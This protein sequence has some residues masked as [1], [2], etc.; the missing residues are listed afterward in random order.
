MFGSLSTK[1]C[2]TGKASVSKKGRARA[3]RQRSK[4]SIWNN[5]YRK[6]VCINALLQRGLLDDSPLITLT[7]A[8]M[9]P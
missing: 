8:A 4:E 1:H 7:S 9:T 3:L 5:V 6:G 2:A